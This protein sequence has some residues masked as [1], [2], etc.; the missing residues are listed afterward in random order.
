MKLGITGYKSDEVILRKLKINTTNFKDN[1][2]YR[3]WE[4]DISDEQL[5]ELDKYWDVFVWYPS[6]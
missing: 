2:D 6:E 5:K 4:V 3:E 1:M